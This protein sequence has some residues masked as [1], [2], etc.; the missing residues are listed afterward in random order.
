MYVRLVAVVQPTRHVI[1]VHLKFAAAFELERN[2][3][4]LLKWLR[5]IRS[6]HEFSPGDEDHYIG[7]TSSGEVVE[8]ETPW[9]KL[10]GVPEGR[11]IVFFASSGHKYDGQWVDGVMQ[12]HGTFWFAS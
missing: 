6:L 3:G 11:G 9:S 1:E 5:S 8:V 12:G 4:L 2:Q 7:E 10:P